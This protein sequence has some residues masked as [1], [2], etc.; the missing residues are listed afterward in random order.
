LALAI[1]AAALPFA[2][3]FNRMNLNSP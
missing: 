2:L 3:I 1:V